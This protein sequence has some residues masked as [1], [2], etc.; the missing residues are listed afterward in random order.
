MAD[1]LE[2]ADTYSLEAAFWWDIA[3]WSH[4]GGRASRLGRDGQ[5]AL[6]RA[7]EL[8]DEALR[9]ATPNATATVIGCFEVQAGNIALQAERRSVATTMYLSAVDRFDPVGYPRLALEVSHNLAKTAIDSGRLDLAES[10]IGRLQSRYHV[11]GYLKLSLQGSWLVARIARGRGQLRDA[12]MLLNAVRD[13]FMEHGMILEA[14]DVDLEMAELA[15]ETGRCAE[16][17]HL[18]R[19]AARLL[20]RT[21]DPFAAQMAAQ[22]PR[23]YYRRAP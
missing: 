1:V 13:R 15:S 5:V 22:L 18:A 8:I 2:L 4:R 23:R 17:A 7:A 19:R 14:A 12:M 21:R 10:A 9:L 6:T 16:A 3:G 20:A 11:V